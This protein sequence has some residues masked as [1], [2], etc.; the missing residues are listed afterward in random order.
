MLA[1]SWKKKALTSVLAL[2][3]VLFLKKK[4]SKL[5]RKNKLHKLKENSDLTKKI[6]VITGASSGIGVEIAKAISKRNATVVFACRNKEKT[7]KVIKEIEKTTKNRKHFFI[8]LDLNDLESV[9][10]FTNVFKKQFNEI[11]ILYNNAGISAPLKEPFV[12]KQGIEKTFGVNHLGHFLLTGLLKS[13]IIKGNC[14][15]INTSSDAHR[16]GKKDLFSKPYIGEAKE[17]KRRKYHRSKMANVLFTK[18]LAR[19]LSSIKEFKGCTTSFHPGVVNTP[20][21]DE[22]FQ[23]SSIFFVLFLKLLFFPFIIQPKEG[24]QTGIYLGLEK[25][26]N[27]K[28]GEYYNQCKIGKSLDFMNDETLQDELW[29]KSEELCNQKFDF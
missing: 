12:T 26:E 21:F 16:F 6:V 3:G 1:G 5:S 22:L 20:I 24:A 18:S 7:Q 13:E 17:L 9:K 10:N 25:L 8:E 19:K 15:I 27:L 2:G 28:S 29:K 23:N 11:N 4:I 14:R